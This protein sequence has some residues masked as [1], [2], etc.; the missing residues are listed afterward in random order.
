MAALDYFVD[1]FW[2]VKEFFPLFVFR[3]FIVD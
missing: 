3:D 2:S 1:W